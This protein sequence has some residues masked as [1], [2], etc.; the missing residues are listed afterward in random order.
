VVVPLRAASAGDG[1][2]VVCRRPRARRGRA[3]ADALAGPAR[4]RA[5]WLVLI[6][7]ITFHQTPGAGLDVGIGPVDYLRTQLG[8]PPWHYLRLLVWPTQQTIEYDWPLATRWASATVVVPA[9]G[10]LIV[11]SL[12]GWLV[13]TG[14]RAAAFWL[15]LA[16]LALAPSSSIVPIADLVFEHR[17]YLPLAGF[18]VL[19]ALAGVGL[20]R[21][22]PR[23]V[24]TGALAAVV[25]LGVATIA[26]NRLWHDPVTPVGGR[27]RQG[28]EQAAH[29]PQPHQCLR[30]A[31]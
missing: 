22:A 9:I 29:L 3:G 15:G 8:R 5:T 26:R 2:P 12:L 20:A 30:G 6:A 4:A 19:A 11:L 21:R 1:R 17:M 13:R 25:A 16:L 28:A 24:A 7:L 10:W 31:R 23:L 18:A 14:R 27:A